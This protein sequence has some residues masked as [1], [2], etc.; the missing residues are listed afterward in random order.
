MFL[1]KHDFDPVIVERQR[2]SRC[3]LVEPS[4]NDSENGRGCSWRIH[5]PP[6]TPVDSLDKQ[7]LVWHSSSVLFFSWNIHLPQSCSQIV[8]A[9]EQHAQIDS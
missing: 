1:Y 6:H 5:H 2:L 8:E 3:V 4:D 7:V 9:Q